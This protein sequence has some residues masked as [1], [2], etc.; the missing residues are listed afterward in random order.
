M[1]C[2][3]GLARSRVSRGRRFIQVEW[4]GVLSRGVM[5]VGIVNHIWVQRIR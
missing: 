2:N 4:V 5:T 3:G 1:R